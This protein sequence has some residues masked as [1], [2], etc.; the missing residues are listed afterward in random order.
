MSHLPLRIWFMVTF[1]LA[2]GAVIVRLAWEITYTTPVASLAVVTLVILVT[3]GIYALVLYLFIKPSLKK[4]KSLPV[5]IGVIGIF[6]AGLIGSIVHF[7]R[8]VSSPETATPLSKI[9]AILLLMAAIS[10]YILILW[11]IW[12]IWKSRVR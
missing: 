4:L 5:G 11:V 9:I 2:L 12:S 1:T 3:V 8:F 7:I 6:T 10:G